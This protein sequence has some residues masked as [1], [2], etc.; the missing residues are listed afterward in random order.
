MINILKTTTKEIKITTLGLILKFL[1]QIFFTMMKYI[2]LGQKKSTRVPA[3][4][5]LKIYG[6]GKNLTPLGCLSPLML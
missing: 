2:N 1:L 5:Q 6:Q 4:Q 3:M